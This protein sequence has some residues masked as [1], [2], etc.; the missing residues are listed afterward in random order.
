[1]E[2]LRNIH[3]FDYAATTPTLEEVNEAMLEELSKGWANPSAQYKIGMESKKKVENL[4]KTLADSLGCKSSEFYFTSS[5][6]ESNNWAISQGVYLGRHKGKHCVTTSVEHSSVLNSMK[7][8]EKKGYSVT[9]VKPEGNGRLS[10]EKVLEAIKEETVL[11]SV[12]MVNNETGV[13][14]PVKE[15]SQAIKAKD[16]KILIHCDAVQGFQKIPF[17]MKELDSV[18]LL[19][20]SGHK[21]FAPKGIGGLFIR[22]GVKLPPLL[23]GGG[24]ENG[25]RSGTEAIHQ[26]V[27][28]TKAVEVA[29]EKETERLVHTSEMKF[30]IETALSEIPQV[31]LLISEEVPTVPHIL[32]IS[33]V[34]YPSQVVL[35][36]LS[37]RNIFLSAGSACH[38]GGESHVFSQLNLCKKERISALRI[39][40]SYATSEENIK[41]LV[42]GLKEVVAELEPMF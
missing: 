18:D 11:V 5:G 6:T 38:R 33:L 19:S 26:M 8:L 37:E 4:R 36:F 10:V 2:N 29:K 35:R 39:S 40:V 20:I 24:Q 32:P 1:M 9:Y 13:I 31:K 17:S 41:A 34:G 25:L 22:E 30:Q 28:F 16:K 15:L 3:Y 21:I 12:M 42:D 27:G 7:D 14:F 23:H